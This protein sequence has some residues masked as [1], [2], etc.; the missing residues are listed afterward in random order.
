MQ[1]VLTHI[2]S[3]C[4]AFLPQ[5]CSPSCPPPSPSCRG[6]TIYDTSAG[7][8][9]AAGSSGRAPLPLMRSGEQK[10]FGHSGS[11]STGQFAPDSLSVC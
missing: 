10:G 1:G 3:L 11:S 2:A 5:L 7:K 4:S 6:V 8:G 9:A